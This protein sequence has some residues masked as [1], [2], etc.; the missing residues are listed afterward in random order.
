VVQRRFVMP[1]FLFGPFIPIY[2]FG[3]LRSHS[4][5]FFFRLAS[6]FRFIILGIVSHV[7]EYL[8]GFFAEKIFKL[9]LWDYSEN[10]FNLHGGYASFFSNLDVFA[11]IFVIFIHRR[12]LNRVKLLDDSHIKT[13]AIIFLIFLSLII[14][15]PW[16]RFPLSAGKCLPLR[17]IPEPEQYGD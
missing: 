8:V 14:S 6:I 10:R 11:L 17:R 16:Y 5:I 13:T 9:K 4:G 2:G 15:F 1:V 3:A 12:A 7:F